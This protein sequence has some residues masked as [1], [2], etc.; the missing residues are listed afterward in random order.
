LDLHSL[1]TV[2]RDA[3][4]TPTP[5]TIPKFL[6]TIQGLGVPNRV[7]NQ[8]L[9][10]IGFKSTNDRALVPVLKSL[11]FLDTSG[12]P[13][14]RWKNY[15]DK[16]KAK[17][18]LA[19][20]ITEAYSG[21]FETYPDAYR[22]DNEALRNYFSTHSSNLNEKTLQLVVRTFKSLSSHADFGSP[23]AA[24][25]I[26]EHAGDTSK[27]K[28]V[29]VKELDSESAGLTI[30][31]NIQLQLPPSDDGSVYEKFF[32]AMNKTILARGRQG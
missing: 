4:Y 12:V 22:R 31:I 15:R 28:A 5:A 10:S 25:E 32:E 19:A 6:D 18:V 17:G 2:A 3:I 7:T 30:N 23:V 14:E 8:Y 16:A 29:R 20:A 9:T 11:G 21:L 1:L 13:T 24:D 26:L 27:V